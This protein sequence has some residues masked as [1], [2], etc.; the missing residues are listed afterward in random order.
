MNFF[1]R[2]GRKVLDLS[3]SIQLA[4]L[5][6]LAKLELVK[7]AKPR[8]K[9]AVTVALQTSEGKRLQREFFPTTTLFEVLSNFEENDGM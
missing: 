3:L 7:A 4:V 9:S 8:S 5:P 2:H 1:P 6:N